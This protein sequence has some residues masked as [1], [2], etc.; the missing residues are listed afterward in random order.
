MCGRFVCD[1]PPGI[2]SELF[3]VSAPADIPRSFNIAPSSRILAVRN[4]ET[5]NELTLLRWGFIPSWAKDSAAAKAIINARSETAQEKPFFRQAL[6]KR[7]CII[8]A[9]GFFE[10]QRAESSKQP[11]YIRMK[12]D[13]IMGLAGVWEC[14][15]SPDGERL[16]TCAILTV[17]SNSLI[18]T[19]HDRMPVIIRPENYPLWLDRDIVDP[20]VIKSLCVACP[21]DLLEMYPVSSLV[22]NPR[23]NSSECIARLK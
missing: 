12:L 13:V 6:R 16:E 5:G 11:Y 10:W 22:N 7:R 9:N 15:T 1:M 4:L 23:N 17:S 2:I 3:A 18:R 21:E 20:A 8:P 14:W 19:I